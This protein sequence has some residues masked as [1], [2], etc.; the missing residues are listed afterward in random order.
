[1]LRKYI[2]FIL[3]LWGPASVVAE[4]KP[5]G[6]E[7]REQIFP[8]FL[9]AALIT[10][11]VYAL[12]D[13]AESSQRNVQLL[14]GGALVASAGIVLYQSSKYKDSQ[15]VASPISLGGASITYNYRF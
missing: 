7:F 12:G 4:E 10:W 3:V 13:D 15:I 9:G 6:P 5:I 2:L 14:W 8:L 11:G 1:M